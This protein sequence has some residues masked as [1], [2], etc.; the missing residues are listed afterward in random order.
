MRALLYGLKECEKELCHH[1]CFSISENMD[2]WERP[3][4]LLNGY[5][6]QATAPEA[7]SHSKSRETSLN[8]NKEYMQNRR[9][10]FHL[11]YNPTE[12]ARMDPVWTQFITS[13]QSELVLGLR[14]KIFVL[15]NPGQQ[16]PH[17]ITL[18]RHYTRIQCRYTNISQIHLHPTVTN[19]DK[20]VKVSKEDGSIPPRK[21]TTLRHKYMDLC[22]GEGLPVFHAMIPRVETPLRGSLIDCLYLAG[23]AMAKDLSKKIAVCPLA[24]WW[25]LFK[26][27]G[28]TE[29]TAMSLLNC[30]EVDCAAIADQSTFDQ[31]TGTVT[32]QFANMD[33]FLDFYGKQAWV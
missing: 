11:E 6:K 29:Q 25:H 20:I 7:S 12:N 17:Q 18:I 16:D 31:T 22:T 26:M 23:N 15:P 2:H 5:Y 8:K 24:W 1:Q 9:R 3:L 33:D 21:F 10:L 19:L 27:R 13:G 14:S 28:Y 4:L 30:F 32:N